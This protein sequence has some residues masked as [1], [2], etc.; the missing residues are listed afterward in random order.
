MSAY[1]FDELT[2]AWVVI[3]AARRNLPLDPAVRAA[4]PPPVSADPR[5][6]PF[7]PGHEAETEATVAEITGANDRW[8]VRVVRNRFPIVTPEAPDEELPGGRCAPG[9]GVHEVIVESPAHD[10]DLPRFDPDLATDVVRMYRDRLRALEATP[11]I[12]AVSVFRNHGRRAGSSQSH[13][14]AQVVATAVVPSAVERRYA[15]AQRF[16]TRTG[17]S[18]LSALLERELALE[19]RIVEADEAFVV[20]C[21][22]APHR[23]YETWIVPRE[24]LP[25]FGALD[26]ARLAPLARAL[27]RATARVHAVTRGAAYNLVVRTPP[28]GAAVVQGAYWHLEILPRTGGDAGF[29][30]TTGM[31]VVP[32]PPEVAAAELRAVDP[33][34]PALTALRSRE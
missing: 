2:G 34:S 29:E 30:L 14:H 10:A 24:P 26:D 27:V 3:A 33:A 12:A 21:P 18:P 22:Y 31:D 17:R 32:V 16:A 8:R 19:A 11:G 4:E 13:P 9:L 25:S 7:C 20:L 15:L 23:A 5:A 6:C 28:V 1:R